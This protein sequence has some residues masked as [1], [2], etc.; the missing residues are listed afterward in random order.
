MVTL[1]CHTCNAVIDYL[2]NEK[3]RYL[4]TGCE[5]RTCLEQVEEN[6]K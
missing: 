3:A 4:Y 5:C 6:H 1:I 2:E